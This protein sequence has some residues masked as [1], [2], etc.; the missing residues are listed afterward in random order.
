MKPKVAPQY[1]SVIRIKLKFTHNNSL[2]ACLETHRT[3]QIGQGLG[4]GDERL[5][6]FARV[7]S[8]H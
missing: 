2:P 8:C 5:S 3:L 1:E 7:V 6:K 4:I